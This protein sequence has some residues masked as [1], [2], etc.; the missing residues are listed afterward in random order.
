MKT[1]RNTSGPP[2]AAF[3]SPLLAGFNFLAS[4]RL[5]CSFIKISNSFNPHDQRLIKSQLYSSHHFPYL[6]QC[7]AFSIG[8]VC[9]STKPSEADLINQG[10]LEFEEDCPSHKPT[11]VIYVPVCLT[12]LP[13]APALGR[14]LPR[15]LSFQYRGRL[16]F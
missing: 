5:A 6:L 7:P 4:A 16:L 1:A 13:G 15:I 9:K 10:M 3:R 14:A 2:V 12:S 8:P 11:R